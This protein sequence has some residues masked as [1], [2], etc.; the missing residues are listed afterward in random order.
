MYE[1]SPV[2]KMLSVYYLRQ[3]IGKWKFWDTERIYGIELGMEENL[4]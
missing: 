4:P 1:V 3:E 2:N